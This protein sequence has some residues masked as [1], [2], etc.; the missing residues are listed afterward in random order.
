M[1]VWA[2]ER[3]TVIAHTEV[4]NVEL[5]LT[6][7]PGG[8]HSLVCVDGSLAKLSLSPA[9]E[10]GSLLSCD[11]LAESIP[12]WS[13]LRPDWVVGRLRFPAGHSVGD[14]RPLDRSGS[15][16]F[17]DHVLA[18]HSDGV[19]VADDHLVV[20]AG[21][22]LMLRL[23]RALPPGPAVVDMVERS[24]SGVDVATQGALRPHV[25][26]GDGRLVR[27]RRVAAGHYRALF[28]VTERTQTVVV[29]PRVNPGTA[30]MVRIKVASVGPLD[31]VRAATDAVSAQLR[32]ALAPVLRT[33][34]PG[35]AFD[36][37]TPDNSARDVAIITATRDAPQ[38]LE[39][40]LRTVQPVADAGAKLVLI[41]NGTTD[42]RALSLLQEAGNAGAI[43]FRDP[44]PFNF[45][46][47]NNQGATLASR[48]VLVFANNDIA[49]DGTAWLDALVPPLRHDSVGV[50]GSRLLYPSG[51]VQHGGIVWCGDG[52][53][54][55]I[56][57]FLPARDVGAG[58]RQRHIVEVSAVTGALLAIRAPVFEA[59]G[60]FDPELS[61]HM[62][63]ID[64]CFRVRSLGL[65]VLYVATAQAIHHESASIGVKR[66]DN[67]FRRGG[68]HWAMMR[69]REG[70]VMAARWPDLDP[71]YPAQADPDEA[72]FVPRRRS[73]G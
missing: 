5:P 11:V 59:L 60:G 50:T 45:A 70:A 43:V 46:M 17:G 23:Q 58:G 42:R 22:A 28:N 8:W 44:R 31:R 14:I 55:H 1:I 37:E 12:A 61:V 10:R 56:E 48:P 24:G 26:G 9:L 53:A 72:L 3:P 65:S 67:P 38:H 64:L 69:E 49:F 66:A 63:D 40:F 2:A 71:C 4:G 16:L 30:P 73:K 13:R 47:L 15:A 54:E 6:A 32:V 21:G 34:Q 25:V 18:S 57:R 27:L 35:R 36:H 52:H 7:E 62:N 29:L 68:S 19:V 20:K 41:D 51:R 33:A 39:R